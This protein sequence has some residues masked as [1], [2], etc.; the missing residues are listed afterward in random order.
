MKTRDFKAGDFFSEDI[1]I[2]EGS[3]VH[4]SYDDVIDETSMIWQENG[5]DKVSITVPGDDDNGERFNLDEI[6]SLLV[7]I[8]YS[9]S[10]HIQTAG[11]NRILIHEY[12]QTEPKKNMVLTFLF[13]GKKVN[14]VSFDAMIQ[15]RVD[16]ASQTEK[17]MFKTCFKRIME[18]IQYYFGID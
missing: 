14:S 18:V 1:R 3:E 9:S 5:I 16:V 2:P 4:E 11:N 17:T 8:K 10:E 7:Q 15:N 12:Y 6:K 13:N